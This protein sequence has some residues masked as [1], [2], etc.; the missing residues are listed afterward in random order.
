LIIIFTVVVP[1]VVQRLS[2]P[3][4]FAVPSCTPDQ[5]PYAVEFHQGSYVDVLP[6]EGTSCGRA[7]KICARDFQA[8]S[9]EM[10]VDAS[11]S[12]VYQTLSRGQSSIDTGIRIFVGNDLISKNPYLITGFTATFNGLDDGLISGC[13]TIKSV[14]KRPDIL[15]IESTGAME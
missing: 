15:F 9:V 10:L 11:D 13:G 1:V 4:G 14:K 12:E 8:H 5:V 6:D 2:A 7:P 3:P